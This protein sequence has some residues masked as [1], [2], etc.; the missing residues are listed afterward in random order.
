MRRAGFPGVNLLQ[1]E[2]TSGDT[3]EG[4][5]SPITSRSSSP[6]CQG[7]LTLEHGGVY[8]AHSNALKT[9]I[10]FH[11]YGFHTCAHEAFS[12]SSPIPPSNLYHFPT[13]R[14]P[15][16][17][18][19]P[20]IAPTL[21]SRPATLAPGEQEKFQGLM[22]KT[23]T[24][25]RDSLLTRLAQPSDQFVAGETQRLQQKRASDV[26]TYDGRIAT[27]IRFAQTSSDPGFWSSIQQR[28][29]AEKEAT[30]AA[31]DQLIAT[32][33][34]REPEIRAKVQQDVDSLNARI[35]QLQAGPVPISEGEAFVYRLILQIESRTPPPTQAPPSGYGDV[36]TS[37]AP[38]P[39]VAGL[40][41][42]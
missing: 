18:P 2:A 5:P 17:P 15:P 25:N 39:P 31:D 26:E 9:I 36:F 24:A 38:K 12:M 14:P 22:I 32:V 6:R 13:P 33:P 30:L 27:D 20:P 23:A 8:H 3:P 28:D 41:G 10:H 19:P 7:S 21:L 1:N 35:A 37:A 4:E 29:M 16:P 42:Y 40:F 34:Q 11:T